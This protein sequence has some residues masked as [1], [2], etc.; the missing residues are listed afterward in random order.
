MRTHDKLQNQGLAIWQPDFSWWT[1]ATSGM[2]N[3]FIAMSDEWQAFMGRRVREDLHLCQELAGAKT[4][5]AMWS[6]YMSFWQK[7][8][9]DYCREYATFT[10]LSGALASDMRAGPQ[11]SEPA[12]PHAQAA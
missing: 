3:S 11:A 1:S 10:T 4:P 2:H 5:E 8:V 7:A 9:E 6:A 12:L